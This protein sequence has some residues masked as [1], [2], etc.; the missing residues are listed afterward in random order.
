[1]YIPGA[2]APVADESHHSGEYHG[3]HPAY[4]DHLE[5]AVFTAFGRW[6]VWAKICCAFFLTWGYFI[7]Q[8]VIF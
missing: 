8:V 5:H 7:G 3:E 4:E 1:M 6:Y 2:I